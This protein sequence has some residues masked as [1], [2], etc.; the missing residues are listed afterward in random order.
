MYL[1]VN[2]VFE[3]APNRSLD[4]VFSTTGEFAFRKNDRIGFAIWGGYY[5]YTQYQDGMVGFSVRRFNDNSR[6]PIGG[7][8]DVGVMGGLSK[9]RYSNANPEPFIGGQ[10]KFGSLRLSRFETFAFEYS[11]SLAGYIVR[12]GFQARVT[13]SFGLGIAL[14]KEVLVR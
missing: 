13:V 12:G 4:I 1:P 2:V 6:A 5:P 3:A 10:L 9:L 8:W 7:Y 14:G 11:G